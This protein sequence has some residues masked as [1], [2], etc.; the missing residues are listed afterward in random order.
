MSD[1]RDGRKRAE[2]WATAALLLGI[3]MKLQV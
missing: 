3:V 2:L 1:D